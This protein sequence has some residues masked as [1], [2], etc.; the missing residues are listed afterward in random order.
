CIFQRIE[1]HGSRAQNADSRDEDGN[2]D[3]EQ[4]D[5]ILCPAEL[6]SHMHSSAAMMRPVGQTTMLLV[7]EPRVYVNTTWL[8]GVLRPP[9]LS[10]TM[11]PT[12]LV[13]SMAAPPDRA[14]YALIG[15]LLR[16]TSSLSVQSSSSVA[17][18]VTG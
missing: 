2:H 12:L 8:A 16:V 7:S 13:V 5:T 14:E 17:V 6:N 9:R 11:A 18:M 15:V 10:N 1:L 3:F 4:R